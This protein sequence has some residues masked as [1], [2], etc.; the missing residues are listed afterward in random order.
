MFKFKITHKL[1]LNSCLHQQNYFKNFERNLI[2]KTKISK[3]VLDILKNF[4]ATV[5]TKN[6]KKCFM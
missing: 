6:K 3:K 1:I 2:H 4:T 5:T